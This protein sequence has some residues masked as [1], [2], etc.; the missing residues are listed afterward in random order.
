M[1][2]EYWRKYSCT[3]FAQ[4]FVLGIPKLVKIRDLPSRRLKAMAVRR[5]R[6]DFILSLSKGSLS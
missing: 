3:T 4:G 5:A 1:R 2:Q 6:A